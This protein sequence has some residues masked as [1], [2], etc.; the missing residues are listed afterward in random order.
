M[1][2]EAGIRQ[3]VISVTRVQYEALE[4]LAEA[5]RTG[6]AFLATDYQHLED[7]RDIVTTEYCEAEYRH[8]NRK[9]GE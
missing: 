8:R 7:I 5:A 9:R 1:E 4:R 2:D 3:F 6:S